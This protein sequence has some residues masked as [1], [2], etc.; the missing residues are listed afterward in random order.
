MTCVWQASTQ[1]NAPKPLTGLQVKGI[2]HAAGL[3]QSE[4]SHLLHGILAASKPTGIFMHIYIYRAVT[5]YVCTIKGFFFL[6]YK[7]SLSSNDSQSHTSRPV[8]AK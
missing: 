7:Y 3:H 2:Q 5:L 4:T 6:S 1:S 8:Q